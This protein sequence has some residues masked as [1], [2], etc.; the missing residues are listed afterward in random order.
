MIDKQTKLKL[1]RVSRKISKPIIRYLKMGGRF[2]YPTESLMEF[3]GEL[4]FSLYED[5]SVT[6]YVFISNIPLTYGWFLKNLRRYPLPAGRERRLNW[7]RE[8]VKE[9]KSI[10]KSELEEL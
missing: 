7:I 6:G 10:L 3:F 1:A 9:N 8:G 2:D 5:P 4:G